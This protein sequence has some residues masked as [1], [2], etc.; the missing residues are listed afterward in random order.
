MTERM[1][2]YE[3]MPS[4]VNPGEFI[5]Y[6]DEGQTLR[7]MWDGTYIELEKKAFGKWIIWDLYSEREGGGR[8]MVAEAVGLMGKG[9]KI[10]APITNDE[11][12][13][14]LAELDIVKTR[15]LKQQTNLVIKDKEILRPL[16]IVYVF[17]AG[18]IKADSM[19]IK[20]PTADNLQVGLK[21]RATLFGRT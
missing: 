12:V 19:L 4:R 8:R 20:P 17:E 6:L 13:D 10:E 16:R 5:N 7:L 14:A 2:G 18:G 1:G 11:T 9:K 21:L 15:V 3:R